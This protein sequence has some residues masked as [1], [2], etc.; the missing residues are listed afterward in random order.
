MDVP[1][2]KSQISRLDLTPAPLSA[3]Q[4]TRGPS[5]ALA[6]RGVAAA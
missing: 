1:F 3:R 5:P 2:R 6:A 4:A